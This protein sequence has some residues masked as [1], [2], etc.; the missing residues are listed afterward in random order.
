MRIVGFLL[1]C[2]LIGKGFSQEIAV[3]LLKDTMYVGE[4]N[5]LIIQVKSNEK[6]P[7]KGK[8]ITFIKS[9]RI[10]KGATL[11]AIEEEVF[12][13]L[14]PIEDTTYYQKNQYL[15]FYR[16]HFTAWD[17]GTFRLPLAVFDDSI[18]VPLIELR[19]ELVPNQPGQEIKGIEEQFV[20]LPS[21]P[22]IFWFLLKYFFWVPIGIALLIFYL[23]KK[24]KQLK[25]TNKSV[26]LKER[27]LISLRALEK[28]QRWKK[29]DY[30]SHF[31]EQTYLL[32]S[33]LAA[34]YHVNFLEATSQETLILLNQL[35]LDKNLIQLIMNQLSV[36]DLVKFAKMNPQGDEIETS[37]QHCEEIVISTSP[38]DQLD[39]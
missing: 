13:L 23:W 25:P 24:K 5:Q 16:Y 26:N 32:K 29:G 18:Q 37:Y 19:S 14:Q 6:L 22:S 11:E 10:Q 8:E 3:S 30:K 34:R 12:E 38:L 9:K 2:F 15:H 21:D 28:E 4:A 36:S 33:Y 35:N 31:S 17:S 1:I 7:L 27:T 20:A 39:V